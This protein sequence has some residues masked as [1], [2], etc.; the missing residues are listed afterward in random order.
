[1]TSHARGAIFLGELPNDT[2]VAET[3]FRDEEETK[4]DKARFNQNAALGTRTRRLFLKS[5]LGM[6]GRRCWLPWKTSHW[7]WSRRSS[8]PW[9]DQIGRRT[10]GR[11]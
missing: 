1:V 7:T 11:P 10:L 8:M 2:L 3:V 4:T 9:T 5:D 6:A